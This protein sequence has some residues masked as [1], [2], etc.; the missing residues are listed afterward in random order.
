LNST[1]P[2]RPSGELVSEVEMKIF[3]P[4]FG[5]LSG[6]SGVVVSAANVRVVDEETIA[7]APRTTRIRNSNVGAGLLEGASYEYSFV[8]YA[9][10]DATPF[11]PRG[12]TFSSPFA[13]FVALDRPM[14]V[15]ARHVIKPLTNHITSRHVAR[16][17]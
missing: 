7:V 8:Y 10:P 1:H 12:L 5:A 13:L 9:G 15:H 16:Q 2:E 6:I 17:S 14:K 4:F 11:L 3:D